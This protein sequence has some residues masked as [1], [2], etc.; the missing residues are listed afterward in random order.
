MMHTKGL[1]GFLFPEMAERDPEHNCFPAGQGCGGIHEVQTCKQ[2][3]DEIV[4][5][6]EAILARG[7][8]RGEHASA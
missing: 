7:V 6:A 2:I 4:S 3:V 1:M 8:I 5:Q